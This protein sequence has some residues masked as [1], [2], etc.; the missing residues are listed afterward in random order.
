MNRTVT[1]ILTGLFIGVILAA[2]FFI[3]LPIFMGLGGR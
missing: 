2:F 1:L 3:A